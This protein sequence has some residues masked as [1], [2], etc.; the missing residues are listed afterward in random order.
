MKKLSH[1]RTLGTFHPNQI[2]NYAEIDKFYKSL[3][4]L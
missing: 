4:T 1:S 3:S 2:E